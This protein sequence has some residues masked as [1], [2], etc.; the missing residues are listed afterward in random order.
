MRRAEIIEVAPRRVETPAKLDKGYAAR[1]RALWPAGRERTRS[2]R[3]FWQPGGGD[4]NEIEVATAPKGLSK[5]ER[6]QDS[7]PAAEPGRSH[8]RRSP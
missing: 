3:R 6:S 5:L 8:K 4:R 7:D 1:S 2:H